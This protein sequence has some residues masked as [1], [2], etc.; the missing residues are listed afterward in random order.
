M[1]VTWLDE[2]LILLYCPGG[3]SN[4]RPPVASYMGKV[5]FT[6]TVLP[7]R[8]RQDTN[9]MSMHITHGCIEFKETNHAESDILI[10]IK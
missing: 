5:S 9:Q 2:K 1:P 10:L 7:T 4:S 6:L 3:G 8:T